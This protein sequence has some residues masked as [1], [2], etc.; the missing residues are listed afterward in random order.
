MQKASIV[1]PLVAGQPVH[2]KAIEHALNQSVDEIELIILDNRPEKEKK[3]DIASGIFKSNPRIYYFEKEFKNRAAMMNFAIEVAKSP[4]LIINTYGAVL[5][6]DSVAQYREAMIANPK[7]AMVYSDYLEVNEE[8]LESKRELY[9]D[10]HEISENWEYGPVKAYRIEYLDRVGRFDESFFHVEDYDLKLRLDDFYEMVIIKEPLYTYYAKPVETKDKELSAKLHSGKEGKLGSFTYLFENKDKSLE[11]ERA[12]KNMLRRRGA[13][14]YHE[15]EVIKY[16]ANKKWPVTV[17]VII[18]CYNRGK[19]IGKAIDSVLR[20]T[21][22]DFEIIVVDNGSTDNSIE[23]VEE[24]CK[25]DKRIHLIKNTI[26]IIALSLNKGLKAAKGKYYAQ[27]DSDDEYAPDCLEYMVGFL[28]THPKCCV[29]VSYYQLMDENSVLIP[30]LG[31]IDHLE[32]D[33]NNIMRVGGA[34][35]LRVYHREIILKEFGGFDVK[36][37]GQFGED[38]DLNLRISEKYDIGRVHHVCYYYRRHANNTDVIRDPYMKLH[39]KALARVR[40]NNRRQKLNQQLE[41]ERALLVKKAAAAKAAA[42][43][44][45]AAKAKKGKTV[46]KAKK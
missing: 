40:A 9:A 29:A 21:Y 17:S 10:E 43:P 4:Y 27:L 44:A 2:Q 42:K 14:L 33:R 5:N 37:F 36:D 38:Y 20:Q 25:K 18:P 11:L 41:K 15:N 13:F 6:V 24:Y 35:A 7:A 12:C 39:N 34:G 8:G 23:V 3:Q 16:P 19:Y 30:E 28:E 31:T 46:K 22:Q 45:K 32:Y 26:N 1:M